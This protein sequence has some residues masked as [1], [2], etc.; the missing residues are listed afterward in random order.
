MKKKT[1]KIYSLRK[2]NS[3]SKSTNAIRYCETSKLE[4]EN[5]KLGNADITNIRAYFI[6]FL[7]VNVELSSQSV[8]KFIFFFKFTQFRCYTYSICSIQLIC[9]SVFGTD[10]FFLS[11]TDNQVFGNEIA[12]SFH[13]ANTEN[14]K[15]VIILKWIIHSQPSSQPQLRLEY[16]T[17]LN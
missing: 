17:K 6:N 7:F 16:T 14:P 1:H 12:F 5:S 15:K 2:Q 11:K 3:K 4:T 10:F 9:T 13:G 8:S